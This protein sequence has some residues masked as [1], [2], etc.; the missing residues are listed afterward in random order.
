MKST[1]SKDDLQS[2]E[3][4]VSRIKFHI[5]S[6]QNQ[7]K[8][9]FGG[10]KSLEIRNVNTNRPKKGVLPLKLVFEGGKFSRTHEKRP[11][12]Q[13]FVLGGPLTMKKS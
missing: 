4:E 2:I 7:E 5:E 13:N 6:T 3:G 8:Q 11:I 1:T 12:S 10:Q 9:V